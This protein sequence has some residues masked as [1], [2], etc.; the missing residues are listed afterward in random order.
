VTAAIFTLAGVITG[1]LITGGTQF[2]L[3]V[4]AEKREIRAAARLMLNELANTAFTFRYA[5]ENSNRWLLEHAADE[6]EWV[7]H[8]LLLARHL[9][10][11][12]W[13]AVALGYGE[14]GATTLLAQGDDA[15]EQWQTAVRETLVHVDEACRVLRARAHG[16][17][18]GRDPMSRL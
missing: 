18:S 4:R 13:D 14:A 17:G 11:D 10:S 9:S 15:D 2:A 5:L 6:E 12:E 7:R 3:Q 1:A 8:H 16:E